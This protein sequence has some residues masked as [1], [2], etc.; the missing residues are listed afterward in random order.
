MNSEQTEPPNDSPFAGDRDLSSL[1]HDVRHSLYALR[2]GLG[3][4][5]ARCHEPQ[6]SELC[7]ALAEEERTAAQLIEELL[8]AAGQRME[9]K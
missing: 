9:G 2:T 3:L 4:L 8:T 1:V 6:L 7:D 5:K